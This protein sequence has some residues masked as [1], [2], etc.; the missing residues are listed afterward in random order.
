MKYQANESRMYIKLK[1]MIFFLFFR[2]KMEIILRTFPN[3]LVALHIYAAASLLSA[4]NDHGEYLS[5]RIITFQFVMHNN[6]HE[7]FFWQPDVF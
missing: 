2:E 5:T 6:Q 3:K 4:L 1:I 7:V